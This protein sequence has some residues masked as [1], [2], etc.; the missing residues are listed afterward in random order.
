MGNI[1]SK[2]LE[3][4]F[5]IQKPF[6][7]Y[8][9]TWVDYYF[10]IEIPVDKLK[11][12]EEFVFPFPRITF[13]YFFNHP[14]LVT[15]HSTNENHSAEMIISRI[16]TNQISVKPLTDKVKIIGAHIKPYALALLTNENI[17][18]MPWIIKTDDLFKKEAKKFKKKIDSCSYPKEMFAEVENIFLSSVL[19][20]DVGIV[21]KAID[22]IE[23]EKG[24]ISIS[25][26]SENTGVT[27]RTLRNHFYKSVGCSPKEYIMLVKLR[28]SIYQMKYSHDSLTSVSYSQNFADQAH[29]T[30]TV[31]NIFGTHPKEIKKNLPNFRFL[32]F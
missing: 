30:N 20:K 9:K 13:G 16:S 12:D 10:F 22:L 11:L 21:I 8:L 4:D 32:Q 17:S 29:F 2:K 24:N 6:N 1:E 19:T 28:Q 23:E 5:I 31:K 25:K 14:F 26:L 7:N 3:N 18:D 27:T 15:N